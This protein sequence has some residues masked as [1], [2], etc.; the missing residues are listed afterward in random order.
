[1][2]LVTQNWRNQQNCCTEVFFIKNALEEI[3]RLLVSGSLNL[4]FLPLFCHLITMVTLRLPGNC[5]LHVE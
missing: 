2:V 1:M 4:M 5:H 3:V